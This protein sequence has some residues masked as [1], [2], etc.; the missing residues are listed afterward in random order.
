M[1]N[2]SI[3]LAQDL[4]VD[5][6]ISKFRVKRTRSG[7]ETYTDK[8]HHGISADLL[9]RKWGIVI[10]K[11]KRTLRSTTQDNVIPALKPLTRRYITDLLLQ[12]LRRLNCIFYTDTIFAKDKY[13]FGNT[14]AQIFTNGECFQRITMIYK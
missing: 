14:C 8:K 10:D 4:M 1:S 9:S 7:F 13:I 6:L 2:V 5:I 11:E 3:G 12:R